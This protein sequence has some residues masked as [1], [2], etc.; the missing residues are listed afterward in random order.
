MFALLLGAR[1]SLLRSA[2]AA[3]ALVGVIVFL[4]PRWWR[5]E[6]SFVAQTTR[7]QGNLGALSGVASQFGIALPA[8]DLRDPPQFYVSLMHSRELLSR[9]IELPM[10]NDGDASTPPRTLVDLLRKG[11]STLEARRAQTLQQLNKEMLG[12]SVDL[13]SGLVS[14]SIR[15]KSPVVSAVLAEALLDAVVRF[16]EERR[17]SQAGAERRFTEQ[18]LAEVRGELRDAE[19]KLARF[20]QRNRDYRNAPTLVFEFDRL[21]RDVALRQ[22]IF[23]ALSQAFEQARIEEVRDTPILTVVDTPSIPAIPEPRQ[24]LIK[25]FATFVGVLAL[26]VVV[27]LSRAALGLGMSNSPTGIDELSTILT[28]AL[29]DLRRPWR[30]LLR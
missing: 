12:T 29:S 23:T 20:L 3:A 30:L 24:L 10:D 28:D 9:L 22:Q 11:G 14:F 4:R 1:R 18:R 19:D 16:N 7:L 15:S 5:S 13:R 25:S 2:V 6:G 17:Q 21:S 26:G 8:G 27:V